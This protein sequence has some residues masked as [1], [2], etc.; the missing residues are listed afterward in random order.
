MPQFQSDIPHQGSQKSSPG[1]EDGSPFPALPGPA[2]LTFVGNVLGQEIRRTLG[3]LM[4]R[5]AALALLLV[6][7]LVLAMA[8]VWHLAEAAAQAGSLWLGNPILGNALAGLTLLLIPYAV[9][10]LVWKRAQ[11]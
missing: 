11:S 8:G 10:L 5:L 7:G 4:F 2:V 9:M 6:V 1:P 3:W